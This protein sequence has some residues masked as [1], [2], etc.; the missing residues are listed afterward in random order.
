MKFKN[1]IIYLLV[2]SSGIINAQVRFPDISQNISAPNS[3]AFL[4]ASSST[5]SNSST[6]IAK[7]LLYPRVDLTTFT[8]FSGNP[9]GIASSYPNYYDGFVVYNTASSGTAGVGS[10]S[11]TLTA[12]FWY[13]ENKSGTINGGTWKSL[14]NSGSGGST[15][16]VTNITTGAGLTG[17]PITSSGT[18][19]M[20]NTGVTAGTYGTATQIPQITVNALGQITSATTV[21]ASGGSGG[22]GTSLRMSPVQNIST[23]GDFVLTDDYDFWFIKPSVAGVK[24]KFPTSPSS[25]RVIN[26]V[27]LSDTYTF[28]A[29]TSNISGFVPLGNLA[30]INGVAFG[31]NYGQNISAMTTTPANDSVYKFAYS[32]YYWFIPREF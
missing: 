31:T 25:G 24:V 1:I 32:G 19:S 10:T 27:N 15:G 13:Y 29:G 2:V 18:I 8:A 16:T 11:G 6:N 20:L 7:G 14:T 21:A 4:D 30:R 5:F 22:S 26:I 23:A 28:T 3:S 12:G 17:G 9:V